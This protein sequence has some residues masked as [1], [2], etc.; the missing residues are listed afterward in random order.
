MDLVVRAFPVLSGKEAEMRQFARDLQTT[1]GDEA[2]SFYSSLG[3][4]HESW[5]VQAHPEGLWVIVITEFSAKGATAAADEYA[6]SHDGFASWFKERVR[7]VTGIDPDTMPLGPP[8]DCVL[9]LHAGAVIH[10]D[11]G[12]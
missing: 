4:G 3:I 10:K 6:G 7:S 9:H 2:V 1:R 5:H 11:G 8:T 12:H